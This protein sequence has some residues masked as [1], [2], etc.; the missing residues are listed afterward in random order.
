MGCDSVST[1]IHKSAR[2]HALCF[3]RRGKNIIHTR[4]HAHTNT[5]AIGLSRRR[6][7]KTHP[8]KSKSWKEEKRSKSPPPFDAL[9]LKDQRK[10]LRGEERK[11]SPSH[12]EEVSG[13]REQRGKCGERELGPVQ[14]KAHHF[15]QRFSSP[16]IRL[17]FTFISFRVLVQPVKGPVQKTIMFQE[18]EEG[19]KPE[20]TRQREEECSVGGRGATQREREREREMLLSRVPLA[21]LL[22]AS[23]VLVLS[24]IS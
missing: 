10:R 19:G 9:L 7:H 11:H 2:T 23:P 8:S 13:R 3:C 12:P 17:L 1:R 16:L 24:S 21:L 18:M 15:R 6:P 4:A 14:H 5:Q 20:M 22:V